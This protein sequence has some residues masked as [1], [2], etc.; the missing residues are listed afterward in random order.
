MG[1]VKAMAP[2]KPPEGWKFTARA[3]AGI[4]IERG[5]T[6][7][8]TFHGDLNLGLSKRPHRITFYGELNQEKAGD[9]PVETE[10]NG[11]VN[12]DYNRFLSEKW[13]LFGNAQAQ[14]DKFAD[15]DLLWAVAA[16][17]VTS[18]GSPR[19]RTSP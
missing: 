14:Q 8:R 11:L 3:S 13:Y 6:E 2:A 7:K 16:G 12:L 1:Q 10:D 15:L 5:N 4:N 17:R 18:S 19:G 9:P